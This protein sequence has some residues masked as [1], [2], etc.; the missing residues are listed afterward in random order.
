MRYISLTNSIVC[1]L[2][3]QHREFNEQP[4]VSETYLVMLYYRWN[5][6]CYSRFQF[7]FAPYITE[8]GKITE[9]K[10]FSTCFF[11]LQDIGY[12]L[13][14]WWWSWLWQVALLL[15]IRCV[16]RFQKI[17]TLADL[18][19]ILE[20]CNTNFPVSIRLSSL[21]FISAELIIHPLKRRSQQNIEFSSK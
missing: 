9:E 21:L 11:F 18:V 1:P 15:V 13:F 16:F 7:R 14:L 12:K 19:R 4:S 8:R 20:I 2:I 3:T 10:K 6:G 17:H 5:E